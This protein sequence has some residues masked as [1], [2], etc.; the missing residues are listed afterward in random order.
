MNRWARNGSK[1][2]YY[3]MRLYE[4]QVDVLDEFGKAGE[5]ALGVPEYCELL[6]ASGK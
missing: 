5:A 1:S 6:G 2:W 4:H 3:D